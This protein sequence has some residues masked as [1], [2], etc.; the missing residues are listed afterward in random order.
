MVKRLST[1]HE[2]RNTKQYRIAKIQMLKTM[3]RILRIRIFNLFR[4]SD[5]GFRICSTRWGFTLLELLVVIAIIAM[6]SSILLP[7]LSKARGKGRSAVCI[8]NLQQLSKALIMYADDNDGYFPYASYPWGGG[9]DGTCWDFKY[10]DY[11]DPSSYTAGLI[12]PYLSDN[13]D[14]YTCPSCKTLPRSDNRPTTGYGYNITYIGNDSALA[15][16]SKI[17]SPANTLLVADCAYW[18]SWGGRTETA[19]FIYAPSEVGDWS[20]WKTGSAYFRHNGSANVAFVDGHV[21]AISKKYSPCPNDSSLAFI[22]AD[23]N[24]YNLD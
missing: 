2:V 16:M 9:V 10:D 14:V 18:N 17:K 4:I 6:L 5:L 21:K 15:K 19:A 12:G 24:A 8:S 3:F 22:S 13:I 11:S 23:D 1:K 20:T 7:A